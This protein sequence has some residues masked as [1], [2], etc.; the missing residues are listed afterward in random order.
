[1]FRIQPIDKKKRCTAFCYG[2]IKTEELSKSLLKE[3]FMVNHANIDVLEDDDY[4]LLQYKN[5]KI[6]RIS[7]RD[8][9][10]YS[11]DSTMT[12]EARIIWEI[13][14]KEGHIENPHRKWYYHKQTVQFL[15]IIRLEEI[16]NKQNR[17]MKNAENVN[18]TA[19]SKTS[20]ISEN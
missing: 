2:R 19:K 8:G 12:Q 18:T 9:F 1:M 5:H 4:F 16:E 10:F 13:L 15:D 3:I 7:K 14:K 17:R 11:Q 20:S 6:L